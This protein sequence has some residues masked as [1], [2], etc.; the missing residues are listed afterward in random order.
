MPSDRPGWMDS[1]C[2]ECEGGGPAC[3]GPGLDRIQKD[4]L[5]RIENRDLLPKNLC[6]QFA[7][8]A[9]LT[10][11]LLKASLGSEQIPHLLCGP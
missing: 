6:D 2:S 4:R 5:C 10:S 11:F 8:V 7:V 1:R 9:I 3:L